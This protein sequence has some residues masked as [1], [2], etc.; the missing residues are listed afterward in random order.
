M[1]LLDKYPLCRGNS[2]VALMRP[3]THPKN[4][5]ECLKP[6]PPWSPGPSQSP[7]R[8]LDLTQASKTPRSSSK[9]LQRPPRF[10][11]G[12]QD[13]RIPQDPKIHPENFPKNGRSPQTSPVLKRPPPITAPNPSPHSPELPTF[14]SRIPTIP[15]HP[16][17]TT[18]SPA[19]VLRLLQRV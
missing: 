13:P 1:N 12:P 5:S 6:C 2:T 15:K 19:S 11:Q 16:T 10:C 3:N 7:K 18:K 17:P 9:E 14:H 8:P 4:A